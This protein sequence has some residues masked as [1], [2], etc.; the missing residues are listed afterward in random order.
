[1]PMPHWASIKWFI[2]SSS[3]HCNWT[4]RYDKTM[5]IYLTFLNIFCRL[6]Q[7]CSHIRGLLFA[8]CNDV[9][10]KSKEVIWALP[11]HFIQGRYQGQSTRNHK[12]FALWTYQ[13]LTPS[14]V[15]KGK[16]GQYYGT[17][18]PHTWISHCL[19]LSSSFR[20]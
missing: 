10:I 9:L 14:P 13:S 7:A 2:S 18:F 5:N 4:L 1:M 8:I 6:A 3:N 11:Q 16:L 17:L 20:R 19:I 12:P 15:K